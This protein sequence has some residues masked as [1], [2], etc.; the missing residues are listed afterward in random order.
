[1]TNLDSELKSRD[2][3]LPTKVH[4]VKAMVFPVFM[5]RCEMSWTIKKAEGQRIDYFE[6]WCWRRLLR[7]PWTARKSN[8]SILKEINPVYSTE[9]LMLKL[10]L[11]Y[12]GHLMRRA[13]SLEKTLMLGK[14]EARK[15]RGRQRMRWL[16]GIVDSMDMGLSKLWEMVKDREACCAAVYGVAE[17]DTTGR[18]N[19]NLVEAGLL[20]GRVTHSPRLRRRWEEDNTRQTVDQGSRGLASPHP[21]PTAASALPATEPGGPLPAAHGYGQACH[22]SPPQAPGWALENSFL[23]CSSHSLNQWLSDLVSIRIHW[24]LFYGEVPPRL[25]RF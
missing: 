24:E 21:Q 4:I 16:D 23:H 12:L 17:S 19:D 1:M 9:G 6:L 18:L 14:I 13:S 7:V 20:L 5:Y 10:K 2:L 15:R 11:Q 8:Q 22:Q 25:K 3:T